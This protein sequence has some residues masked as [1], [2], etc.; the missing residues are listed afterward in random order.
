M[1]NQKALDIVG[2]NLGNLGVTGYTRQR[3][4]Q[5]SLSTQG[6]TSKYS[7]QPHILAG[8]GAAINGVSQIRDPYLDKRFRQE[9]A[10][11]GYFDK[12][13]QVL[14]DVETALDE[15]SNDGMKA[16]LIKMFKAVESMSL[17]GGNTTTNANI[18]RTT[19]KSMTQVMKQFNVKLDN[20]LDQQK[21]DLELNVDHVNS[22]MERI[23][24]LNESIQ[25]DVFAA[26]GKS[27]Y[28]GPNEL[29]DERN[30]LLDELSKYGDIEVQTLADSSVTVTMGGHEVVKGAKAETISY[31]KNSDNTVSVTW[32]SNG[33]GVSMSKGSIFASINMI[34]GRGPAAT[35][36][37]NFER[38]IPYYK[39]QIDSMA[40]TIAATFNKVI[41][42]MDKDGKPEVDAAGD[43]IYKQL[44]SFEAGKGEGAGSITITDE[45]D[46]DS[47][48]IMIPTSVDGK[49]DN[50][51]YLNM[52][53]LFEK[54]LD[55]GNGFV[56]TMEGYVKHYNT[57]LS[58][59]KTFNSSRLS[60][61]SAISESLLDSI[62][63]VSGVSM[64]EEGADMMA[65]NKAYAAMGR[66]MTAL[67]E[68]L[69]VLIN[70]TGVVGR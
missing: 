32:Q 11:V 62:S 7:M 12:A 40:K 21:Y 9:F 57:T 46:K 41:P 61:A 14:T 58:E 52:A 26:E 51:Y 29:L 60:A 25:R 18:V 35:G 63:Q 2:N 3:V 24:S 49:D 55:F 4:D 1:V 16:A 43:V 37:E 54:D 69:D 36:Q 56:G 19:A 27:G 59:D 44:F 23:A 30:V 42:V 31:V 6:M 15:Y 53:A 34:N 38:G 28:F 48:Y 67:D 50:Q 68:A 39:D 10:D 70:R 5:V 65:Y 22:L 66:I 47:T 20:I 33:Q 17:V 45:W 13:T 8:Q 64:D